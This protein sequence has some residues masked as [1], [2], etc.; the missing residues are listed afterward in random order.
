VNSLRQEVFRKKKAQ[1]IFIEY[2]C[3][4]ARWQ[5]ALLSVVIEEKIFLMLENE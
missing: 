3:N 5:R 1:K 4:I 2:F